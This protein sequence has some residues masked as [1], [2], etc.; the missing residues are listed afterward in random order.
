MYALGP[1]PT[2]PNISDDTWSV[3]LNWRTLFKWSESYVCDCDVFCDVMWCFLNCRSA[4]SVPSLV[5]GTPTSVPTDDF[6]STMKEV[7]VVC[8]GRRGLLG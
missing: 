6:Q 7:G 8:W 4:Q 1:F 2:I 5:P 3:N